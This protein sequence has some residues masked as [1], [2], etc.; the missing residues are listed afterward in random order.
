MSEQPEM[1]QPAP[2]YSNQH[3]LDFDW[4][5]VTAAFLQKFPDPALK[6]VTSVETVGREICQENCTMNLRRLFYCSFNVP[7]LAEKLLGK[8]ATVV[9]VEQAHWDLSRRRL[10]VHGRNETGQSVLRID[11]VCCYTEVKPGQTLYTQSATVIYR[12]GLLSGILTPMVNEVLAGICQ[13]NAHKGVTAM[14]ERTKLEVILQRDGEA[15]ASV[16]R[17]ATAAAVAAA[18]ETSSAWLIFPA[19]A[20]CGLG[21]AAVFGFWR[22]RGP[23]GPQIDTYA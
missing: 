22:P 3:L 5:Y 12:K 21:T 1:T 20:V 23:R 16:A 10:T 11:E 19:I 18:N 17:A 8:K 15:A 13:R 2:L 14:V 6:Y 7:R 9:C 4:D